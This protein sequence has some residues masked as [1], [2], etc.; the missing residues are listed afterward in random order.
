METIK[1]SQIDN[2]VDSIRIAF[3][4]QAEN[5]EQAKEINRRFDEIA[6]NAKA[7]NAF[8]IERNIPKGVLHK[9]LSD[10]NN[11]LK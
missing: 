11:R 4:A 10:L 9:I 5:K 6:H 2:F 1:D 7:L 3:L 8:M